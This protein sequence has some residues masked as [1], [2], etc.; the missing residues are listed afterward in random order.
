MGRR[1]LILIA[2]VIALAA[3][4]VA[5]AATPQVSV[6]YTTAQT[7]TMS[8]DGAQPETYQTFVALT[9][10][11]TQMEQQQVITIHWHNVY[12]ATAYTNMI[13]LAC[14]RA[15]DNDATDCAI[16]LATSAHLTVDHVVVNYDA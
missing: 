5:H 15:D 16:A 13:P 7:W 9:E 6:T 2:M 14:E 4:S 12:T 10:R 11:L 1:L 8:V 3:G